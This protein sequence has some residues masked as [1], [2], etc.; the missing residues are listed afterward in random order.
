[1]GR[2]REYVHRST[3]AARQLTCTV[4]YIF[5]VQKDVTVDPNPIEVKSFRYLS[6]P[7]LREFLAT[8]GAHC[9]LATLM[10]V[11]DVLQMPKA[12][13]SPRGSASLSTSTNVSR[14][15]RGGLTSRS[16]L[17]PWWDKLAALPTDEQTVLH[18]M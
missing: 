6:A 10:Y 12:S 3:V 17:Y 4:D 2:A 1:M 18:R 11:C 9:C 16:F 14:W 15:C 5:F 13:P 8:A 7:E